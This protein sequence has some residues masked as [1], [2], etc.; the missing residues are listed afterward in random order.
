VA[1]ADLVASRNIHHA[2]GCKRLRKSSNPYKHVIA[3]LHSVKV[4]ITYDA[5][6]KRVSRASL[7]KNIAEIRITKTS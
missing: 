3:L 2:G 5:L 7:E 6:V 1:I 4:A